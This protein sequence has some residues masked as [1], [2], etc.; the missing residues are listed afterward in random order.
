MFEDLW[1]LLCENAE[2]QRLINELQGSDLAGT[3]TPEQERTVRLRRA[4][5]AQGHLAHAVAT[6]GDVQDAE[7]DAEQ[8]AMLLWKH[9]QLHD[10]SRGPVPAA[11]PAWSL[12]TVHQYVVQ[13]ARAATEEEGR[14]P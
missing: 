1:D 3:T 9:D 12:A 13:E 4:V 14:W 5:L 6:G 8:T 10:S 7:V 11:D 2:V